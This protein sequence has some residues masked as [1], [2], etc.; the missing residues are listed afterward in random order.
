MKMMNEIING[1]LIVD[2]RFG[3]YCPQIFAERIDRTLFPS[4]SEE[5]WDILEEGPEA[6]HYWD[7]WA[8]EVEGQTSV[9]GGT[10]YQD[11][12]VWIVYEWSEEE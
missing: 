10:I 11:G 8:Y 4:I 9:N 7:V 12:D 1:S 6:E 3:I 5:A 2:S